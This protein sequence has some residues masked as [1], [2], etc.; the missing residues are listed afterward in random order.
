MILWEEA[1]FPHSISPYKSNFVS[2]S[3]D[4]PIDLLEVAE[5]ADIQF[6]N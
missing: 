6:L 4:L 5:I 2:L 3:P 1:F